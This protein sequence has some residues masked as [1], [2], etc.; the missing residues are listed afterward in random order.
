MQQPYIPPFF[1]CSFIAIRNE[2]GLER[3][4]ISH[5]PGEFSHI[6]ESLALSRGVFR[7]LTRGP[8]FDDLQQNRL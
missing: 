6:A 7:A 3:G 2:T 5:E 8:K 4:L 1:F